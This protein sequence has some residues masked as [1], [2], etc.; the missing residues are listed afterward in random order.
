MTTYRIRPTETDE[1]V[2]LTIGFGR[3][4]TGD[5]VVADAVAE[6]SAL[7]L[8]GGRLAR[9]NGPATLAV[10]AALGHK[11]AHL[12]GAVALFDPKLQKYIVAISHDPDRP[13]GT[14]VE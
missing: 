12:Y 5:T 7:D 13:V 11:L 4:A 9:V 14:L 6:L 10:A 2:L 8:K 1:G 3:P